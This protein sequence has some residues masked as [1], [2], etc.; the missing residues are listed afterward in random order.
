M[1]TKLATPATYIVQHHRKAQI[2]IKIS[3]KN[4]IF[5]CPKKHRPHCATPPPPS[6]NPLVRYEHVLHALR[7]ILKTGNGAWMAALKKTGEYLQVDLG[8]NKLVT[9]VSTQGRANASEWVS[10][11]LIKTSLD[12]TA[13]VEYPYTSNKATVGLQRLLLKCDT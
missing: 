9:K 3:Y 4:E 8:E 6:L 2:I 10:A 11:F 13:W 1:P 5:P 7:Y 12:N